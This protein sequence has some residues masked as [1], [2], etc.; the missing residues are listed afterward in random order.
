MKIISFAWT[1]P[2]IR[3]RVKTCT[4]RD[5]TDDYASRFKEGEICLAYDKSPR[6]GGKPIC[7]IRIIEQ[8]Y[9]ESTLKLCPSDWED[10]G[11]D[12]LKA[13][14]A[15]VNGMTP[16]QLWDYWINNDLTKWVIRFE[17]V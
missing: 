11:F 1:T 2:A 8:P 17:Y 16:E 15:K 3:A 13:I 9:K 14:G 5:W 10:E 7:K 12:Y 4:R 6:Y